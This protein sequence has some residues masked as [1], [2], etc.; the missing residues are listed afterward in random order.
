MSVQSLDRYIIM[1]SPKLVTDGRHL[2]RLAAWRPA[3]DNQF[4]VASSYG[5]RDAAMLDMAMS[6]LS[7]AQRIGKGEETAPTS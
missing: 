3:S 2:A 4:V 5:R 6:T 7:R 1:Q